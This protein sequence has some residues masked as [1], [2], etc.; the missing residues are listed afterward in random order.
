[1]RKDLID[2]VCCPV[3]KAGLK[4]KGA[5]LD[6]HGDVLEGTLVC[7]KCKFAYPIEAGIPNLLPPEFHNAASGDET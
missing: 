1:M 3:D 6:D 5:E 4:L 2:I 7:T